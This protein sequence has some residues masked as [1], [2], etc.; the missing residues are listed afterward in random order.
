MVLV[1][2]QSKWLSRERLLQPHPRTGWVNICAEA[3]TVNHARFEGASSGV[4]TFYV[5]PLGLKQV[6][7]V[8][9]AKQAENECTK[10]VQ[11]SV[12]RMQ[13]SLRL[14]IDVKMSQQI[15]IFSTSWQISNF[16]EA[17]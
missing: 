9:R 6:Y 13:V 8:L 2:C 3:Q 5:Y 17:V 10:V 4:P 1:L 16:F 7:A 12:E 15:H 14:R 11:N